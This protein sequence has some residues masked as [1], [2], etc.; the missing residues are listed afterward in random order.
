MLANERKT[1]KFLKW[2]SKAIIAINWKT[3]HIQ[4]G[5]IVA[6]HYK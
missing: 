2:L 3:G 4:A 1:L 6:E 5:I